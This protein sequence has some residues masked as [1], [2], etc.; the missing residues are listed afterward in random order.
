MGEGEVHLRVVKEGPMVR[1]RGSK[2]ASEG[3]QSGAIGALG[4]EG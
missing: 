4:G 2:V 3:L 1:Q